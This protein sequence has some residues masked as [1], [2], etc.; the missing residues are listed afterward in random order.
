MKRFA[1]ADIEALLDEKYARGEIMFREGDMQSAVQEL[2]TEDARYLTPDL[3]VLNGREEILAFFNQIKTHIG[4]VKV[5]PVS[6]WGDP[7]RVVYQLCNTMR[8]PP[9][10]GQVSHAHYLAAF[11]QA[12]EDWLCEMEVVAPGHIDVACASKANHRS[13]S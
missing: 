13:K 4:E 6:L 2:Y 8:R 7:T 9:G 11:R 3:R 5:H 12:G 10:G 1:L